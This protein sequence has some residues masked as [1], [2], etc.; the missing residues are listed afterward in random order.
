MVSA[1]S[2]PFV[3]KDF[4]TVVCWVLH[5]RRGDAVFSQS[6]RLSP[7]LFVVSLR[8]I[9]TVYIYI[10]IY[11]CVYM[12]IYIYT[13]IYIRTSIPPDIKRQR[14]CQ[15]RHYINTHIMHVHVSHTRRITE[16]CM[17]IFV[18]AYGQVHSCLLCAQQD[19]S[20]NNDEKANVR[21]SG[22]LRDPY[23]LQGRYRPGTDVC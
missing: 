22:I 19:P 15:Y 17:Q 7:F 6:F 5:R 9:Y 4:T 14:A 18:Y 16:V 1:E 20:P 13:Y 10:Y 3:D 21:T 2:S 12:C 23:I 8:L 11:L